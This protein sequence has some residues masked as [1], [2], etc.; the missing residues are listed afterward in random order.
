M[1]QKPEPTTGPV[2]IY[3][4]ERK[5][6]TDLMTEPKL[7]PALAETEVIKKRAQFMAEAVLKNYDE[8]LVASKTAHTGEF[9][10][11]FVLTHPVHKLAHDIFADHLSLR[12]V[13][14]N[15]DSLLTCD[16]V[17]LHVQVNSW[18]HQGDEVTAVP[19]IVCYSTDEPLAMPAT[20]LVAAI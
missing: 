2:F 18:Q 5:I 17:Q 12:A 15:L 20:R 8:Y 19:D 16:G 13:Q 9:G 3:K 10:V 1:K 6:M 11:F 14:D 7:N 4:I